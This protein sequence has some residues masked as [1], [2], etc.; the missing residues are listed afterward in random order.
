MLIW[1]AKSGK[2]ELL[3]DQYKWI[4]IPTEVYSEVVEDG[5]REGY[6]DAHVVKEAIK[7]GWIRIDNGDSVARKKRI[8]ND[9]PEIHEGEAAAIAIAL[10][11]DLP[12]LIDESSGRALARALGLSPR[13]V[14]HV[15]LVAL[16][17][18]KLTGDEARDIIASM[19]SSGF[20][21]EPRLLERV[22]REVILFSKRDDPL[23]Q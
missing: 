2:L 1:L 20:R 8:I 23:G 10:S 5:L 4:L 15:V 12:I 22:I 18:G 7:Q 9:L 14:L 19:V 6:S 3:R 21:I 11:K 16:R 13:G 17:E